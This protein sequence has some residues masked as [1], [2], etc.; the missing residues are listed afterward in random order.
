MTF[1]D[2]YH[3]VVQRFHGGGH[4]AGCGG[5]TPE[6]YSEG[7]VREIVRMA[8]SG[9]SAIHDHQVVHRDLKPENVLLLD[10]RG[11]LFDLRIADFG[12]ACRLGHKGNVAPERV[13][14]RGYMA[15]EVLSALAYAPP[16]LPLIHSPRP[17][18]LPLIHSSS[19]PPSLSFTARSPS[20]P[21][22]HRCSRRSPTGWRR[23]SGPSA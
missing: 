7:D 13:G 12:T 11:G 17:F 6:G 23:T 20:R 10:R 22:I 2:L 9:I 4:G 8:L 15:P 16:P 1:H 18:P 14:T 21:L 5:Q 3:Q 19:A